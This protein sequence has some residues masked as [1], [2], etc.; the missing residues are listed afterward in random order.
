MGARQTQTYK[1]TNEFNFSDFGFRNTLLK[2]F[3]GGLSAGRQ[4]FLE[5]AVDT[6]C[7]GP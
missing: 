7:F 3:L 2:G 1:I 6:L 4:D 5:K